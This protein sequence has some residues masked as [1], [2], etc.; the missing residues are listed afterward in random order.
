MAYI[1]D[2]RKNLER[3][4]L[5]GLILEKHTNPMLDAM[6]LSTGIRC[7]DVGCGMGESTRLLAL[8]SGSSGEVV[9]LDIDAALIETAKATPAA[10]ARVTYKQGDARQLPFEDACFDLVLGRCLLQHLPN[11]EVAL[12]E[13]LRVCRRGGV[14]AVQEPD[15]SKHYCFPDNPTITRVAAL[16]AGLIANPVVG[17]KLW[18]LFNGVGYPSANVTVDL[19]GRYDGPVLK[20][21]YVLSL[22]ATRALFVERHLMIDSEVE[23]FL[24]ELKRV[25]QDQAALCLGPIFF[26]AWVKR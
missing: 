6:Q 2:E 17:L 21:V 19:Y 1:F 9:G 20:R 14:V 7:L 15:L 18:P 23:A 5:T 25:E 4:R 10:G 13:M 11:P 3:Q 24:G 8:R 26:S 12:G 16:W 22:E